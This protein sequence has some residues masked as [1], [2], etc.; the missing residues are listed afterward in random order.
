VFEIGNSLRETRTR[1]GIELVEAE[2][3]TKIRARY[4][5]ALEDEQFDQLPAP[6]YVKGFLK[7][8]AEYL[9]LDGSLYVDEYTSRYGSG[10]EL[11]PR[12]PR[13][14]RQRG[15]RERRF[16][17]KIVWLT[18]VG[19]GA[20]TALVIAAWR[21]GG[22]SP[23]HIPLTQQPVK[24]RAHRAPPPGL[25]VRAVR[26]N[27]WLVVRKGSAVGRLLYQGTLERGQAQRFKPTVWVNVG[28]P[29]NIAV[30]LNGRRLAV[31]G[32]KPRSLIITSAAIVPAGPG[33]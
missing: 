26:G 22:D 18:L 6:T 14:S 32:A 12:R 30:K 10:D 4:L 1:R 19:I 23:E 31:G 20:V 25:I 27:S 16:Q 17:A 3:A 28:S 15:R 24:P 5:R 7:A 29:E 13:T 8:Y 9:G 2:Q 33:T 21:F 11:T